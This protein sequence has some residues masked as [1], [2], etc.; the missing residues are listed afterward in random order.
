MSNI[1]EFKSR[2]DAMQALLKEVE[3][4]NQ[5][6]DQM[7]ILELCDYARKL[8]D[9]NQYGGRVVFFHPYPRR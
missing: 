6:S 1:V 9:R 4:F 8:A 3:E 2:H 5:M 7:S